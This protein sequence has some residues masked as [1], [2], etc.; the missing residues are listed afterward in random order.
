MLP[1]LVMI[2]M[3]VIL[4]L[5]IRDVRWWLWSTIRKKNLFFI[6]INPSEDEENGIR[7][8]FRKEKRGKPW[9]FGMFRQPLYWLKE[10]SEGKEEVWKPRELVAPDDNGKGGTP[11][12]F[13]VHDKMEWGRAARLMC[14][15]QPLLEKIQG[16]LM[17]VMVGGGI[18]GILALI[19]MMGKQQ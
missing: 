11:A 5:A 1:V 13:Q 14:Y 9:R 17:A 2:L 3:L 10:D 15:K 19:D 4:P 16:V 18:F 6:W 7:V 8:E 12:P